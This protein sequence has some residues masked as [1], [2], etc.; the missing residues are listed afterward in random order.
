MIMSLL[1][2]LI[3][4]F[5]THR[6]LIVL[7]VRRDIV[8]RTSGT[9]LGAAWM[10]LQP[11][12]QVI[13][14]WFLLDVVLKV[15]F[16]GMAGGFVA[17]YLTGMLPW[18]MLSEVILRSLGVLV[19]YAP[20]YQRSVF[21]LPL[22]PLVPLLVSGTIYTVIFVLTALLMVGPAGALGALGF[23][24]CLLIWLLPFAY[25]FAVL[26][27]FIRD[28]QQA[29]PFVLTIFLYVTPILYAPTAFPQHFQWWLEVNPFAHVMALAHAMVQGAGWRWRDLLEPAALWLVLLPAFSLFRRSERLMRE[30]L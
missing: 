3:V 2:R 1:R 6:A 9:A 19:D 29:A 28:L 25:L 12:L 4:F 23:M 7:L 24:L 22:I 17:F 20:L 18:L 10:I 21:P 8:G 13:A 11:G 14:L 5:R 15:R 16:P 26:G 30:A 27:L